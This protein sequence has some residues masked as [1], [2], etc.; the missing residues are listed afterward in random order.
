MS[1][2]VIV[3]KSGLV[4]VANTHGAVCVHISDENECIGISKSEAAELARVL[5]YFAEHG[6]LPEQEGEK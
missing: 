4:E 3:L 1:E 5:A 6:T 2:T